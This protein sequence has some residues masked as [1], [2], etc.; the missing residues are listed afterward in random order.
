MKGGTVCMWSTSQMR[1]RV[2]LPTASIDLTSRERA[3]RTTGPRL[4]VH[5]RKGRPTRVSQS[6]EG[7]REEGLREARWGRREWGRDTVH[8]GAG[9]GVEGGGKSGAGGG[10]GEKLG[11][12][13]AGGP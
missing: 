11:P 10:W 13:L 4:P 9:R 1:M 6:C 12:W 3:Q 2:S 8:D 7:G 5:V